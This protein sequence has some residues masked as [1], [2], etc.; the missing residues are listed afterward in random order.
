MTSIPV[1]RTVQ[2][3][4]W[5]PPGLL[6]LALI[7]SLILLLPGGAQAQETG[8]PAAESMAPERPA[9]MGSA[10]TGMGLPAPAS[11][12]APPSASAEGDAL[13]DLLAEA[14][15]THPEIQAARSRVEAASARIPQAGALPDPNLFAGL[16]YV[17]LPD[18]DISAEGMTMLSLQFGQRLPPRGLRGARERA[19]QAELEAARTEVEAT[20]WSV[21]LRLQEAYFELLLV[22]EAE[23]VHHRTHSALEAFAASAESAFT[24]GLAPQQDILRAQTELAGI[25]EHL[26]ELRQR[27][28]VAQAQVNALLG[29]DSRSPI[30]PVMPQRV[31]RLLEA[32]PGP[33]ILTS[34]LVD[35]ELG[36]GL[37]TLA[38]L[39]AEAL[40]RRP[41]LASARHRA[42]AGTH[43]VE[44][45]RRDRRPGVSLTGGYALRSARS[46][47]VSV[48][49]S[50]DLPLFRSRKQDQAV[51]EAEHALQA[52]RAGVEAV[53][54]EIR[55]EVAEAHAD[56]IQ[57]REQVILLEEGIIPQA[58]A[59]VQ[60]ASGA[61]RSGDSSFVSLM[62][63]YAVLF[64]NEIQLAHLS[65]EL[66]TSLVRLE[67]AVGAE[68]TPE[69]SR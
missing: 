23:A 20:E 9:L 24:Q 35:A 30:H 57:V 1:R 42:E 68:L 67:R 36:G 47:M 18:F 32:D 25:E 28:S 69:E 17:P 10:S 26:A 55:E 45:A 48:G 3:P 38:A 12:G 64:R 62:E 21:K 5:A 33:G 2:T 63:V 40:G 8:P 52:D 50:V 44:A 60:S 65:A 6:H 39:Q 46:D 11:E 53:E 56:L 14:L 15:A 54:R 58:R 51:F 66:G 59:T 34:Y 4:T 31:V 29:R 43:R 49:V 27:R 16:M 19:A 61:Y 22:V 13:E 41:E 37:P 7:V